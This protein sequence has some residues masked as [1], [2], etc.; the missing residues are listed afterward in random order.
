MFEDP[1]T[2]DENDLRPMSWSEL[3]WLFGV[4]TALN[5]FA[6]LV[7]IPAVNGWAVLPIE[8]TY[9][10]CVG[11]FVLV[12]MFVWALQLSGREIGSFRV[13]DILKRMRVHRIEGHDWLW[14]IATFLT[15]V[16]ASFL[17]A[18]ILMPQFGM[19][20]TPFFFANMPLAN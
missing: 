13:R 7:A 15:L 19:D 3:A 4:P 1:E 11:V 5:A 10:L 6:C 8:V 18:K 14:T 9:F 16:A 2:G 12:P 20:A 17:I